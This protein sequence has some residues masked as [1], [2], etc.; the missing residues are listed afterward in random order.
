MVPSHMRD[1]LSSKSVNIPCGEFATG[2]TGYF[3]ASATDGSSHKIQMQQR[4]KRTPC[5]AKFSP[6]LA[7]DASFHLPQEGTGCKSIRLEPS[8]KARPDDTEKKSA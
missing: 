8:S 2:R 5:S 1:S 7:I 3:C 4:R 6:R